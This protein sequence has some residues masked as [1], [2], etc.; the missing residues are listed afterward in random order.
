MFDSEIHGSHRV[1]FYSNLF[2][3]SGNKSAVR[4]KRV[5]PFCTL[6]TIKLQ[7]IRHLRRAVLRHSSKRVSFQE[8]SEKARVKTF[9][10]GATQS[11]DRTVNPARIYR[12]E[13]RQARVNDEEAPPRRSCDAAARDGQRAIRVRQGHEIRPPFPGAAFYMDLPFVLLNCQHHHKTLDSIPLLFFFTET[14][15]TFLAQSSKLA[16]KLRKLAIPNTV[17]KHIVWEFTRYKVKKKANIFTI[18]ISDS[19]GSTACLFAKL[20]T[21][22]QGVHANKGPPSG[23]PSSDELRL[24]GNLDISK[25]SL[26]IFPLVATHNLLPRIS[27][28]I[29]SS[30]RGT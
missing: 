14:H 12:D 17:P 13:S 19:H 18:A 25:R 22:F 28:K 24:V 7:I 6:F 26:A 21:S 16:T 20:M 30:S 5:D 23:P 27:C 1:Y 2:A 15:H 29:D 9:D 8:S 3:S 4:S 10:S 11:N